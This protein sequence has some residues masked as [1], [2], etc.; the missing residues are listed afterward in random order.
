MRLW[1]F[2]HLYFGLYG[3][4][5][6]DRAWAKSREMLEVAQRSSVRYVLAH[7]SYLAAQHSFMRGDGT[8]AQKCAEEAVALAEEMGLVS[9][10]ALAITWHGAALIAQGRYEEGIAVMR[11][12][13]SS[14]RASGRT[15]YA[16]VLC[17]LASGLGR[18]GR[19]EKGLQV[20]EDGFASVAKTREQIGSPYLHH[21]K[22]ELSL[23][24]NPSDCAKAELCFRTAIELPVGKARDH[25]NCV[26]RRASRAC[27]MNR[28][29]A[30][31]LARCS[32]KSTAG[33][34]R[35]S[36]LPI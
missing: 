9:L 36:T 25:R 23:A 15:P 31:R 10:S 28:V 22:G 35:A 5:Y 3:L 2:T 4:G 20:V 13:I 7:A 17:I 26:P 1:S 19:P 6:P 16:G 8:A 30:T 24:Q 33:S 32:A 11:R 27:S 21:V 18:I 29:V 12:G 14:V 34:P